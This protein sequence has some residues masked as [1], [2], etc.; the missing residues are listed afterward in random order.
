MAEHKRAKPKREAPLP[1]KAQVRQ[2]IRESSSPVGKREIAR[3][4][5]ISGSDRIALKAMLKELA[6]EG[7]LDRHEGRRVAPSGA[8]PG[9]A[10]LEVSGTDLDGE[11][12]ARPVAWDR[13]A[14]SPHIY[15]ADR[16]EHLEPALETGDRVLAR[17]QRLP[18]NTYEARTIRRLARQPKRVVGVLRIGPDGAARLE[19]AN[20]RERDEF[21]VAAR[22]LGQAAS[23]DLVV[24]E[25]LPSRRL[26][27]AHARVVERLGRIGDPRTISL[28]S[29]Q[30][31]AIPMD[32]P[33]AAV[34]EAEAAGPAPLDRR[35]D[36]RTVPLVTIDG[37]DA[38]D[39]DDAVWAAPDEDPQNKG[40]WTLLVAIADVAWYVRPGSPLDRSAAERGNSVY[41]PDRVVP[42]LPEALSN[43]WCSLKPGEERP[44]MAV[45]ITVDRHGVKRSH[46]FVRGLMRSAA[47][48]TYEQVQ[49]AADGRPDAV[50]GPLQES[51]IRPLYG[52]FRAL[53]AAR[54]KR[55]TLDLD[56]AERRVI[57][58]EDGRVAEIVPRQRLD[59]HRLIE[60]FMIA[61]N[62]AAAETLE[63]RRA[64]VMYR[65][66]DAPDPAKIESLREFL[67]SLGIRLA[68]GQ[69]LKPAMFTQV[70]E[71]AAKTPFAAMVNELVL[72]SQAQA[73][74]GPDNV[75]HFGLALRR[76][77][78]FTSPIR[79]YADLL[80]HRSLISAYKLGE[81][82]LPDD[83][84]SAFDRI[85]AAISA[86]E[87]RAM[88]AER[89][90]VD[91]YTAAYLADK[92]GTIFGARVS[93]VT[94]FGLFATL[95]ESGADGLIPIS[96]L[97]AD[98]YRHEE[99]RHAL[100]GQR[101]GRVYSLGEPV[102]VR[103]VEAQPVTGGLVFNLV[104]G[105]EGREIAAEPAGRSEA[106][107]GLRRKRLQAA[108][109]AKGAAKRKAAR[110]K[111]GEEERGRRS[112]RR[113]SRGE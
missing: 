34:E 69:V 111:G 48:L 41:F 110:R 79:R 103:L 57:L 109:T 39:F 83:Q 7:A 50:T 65:I 63:A 88:A 53:L 55:G 9:V 44:C 86:T 64:P 13:D 73:V 85:G 8:L 26:G 71:K 107:R 100:V 6:E 14:P 19:P 94:R 104:E 18:D 98:F 31:H 28:I 74:Y 99:H 23:G 47:R 59:S 75:G 61:A 30:E 12:L 40:G 16:G 58:G 87:R 27:L 96:T 4:F 10:V 60:E 78:H 33:A 17:L 82:G 72:R 46:R 81:G 21:T 90:A 43:G 38:R 29:I 3:A 5:Q 95:D 25:V 93:G 84:A 101:W 68:R 67:D 105:A 11:L 102:Q 35:T 113:R 2:F 36:L 22:D 62:V 20:R 77:A 56:I 76:Y 37:A 52:A 70:L 54:E 32:F 66:H 80:V 1:S 106:E 42:M 24:A 45:W 108:R 89:G 91:R 92:V 97:P 15:I 51:V 112:R 49:D